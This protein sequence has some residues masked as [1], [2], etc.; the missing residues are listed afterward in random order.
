VYLLPP[1]GSETSCVVDTRRS[2]SASSH[3]ELFKL[4]E[5]D[6]EAASPPHKG[7]DSAIHLESGQQRHRARH[8]IGVSSM[9]ANPLLPPAHMQR[10]Y[11]RY[12]SP[13]ESCALA[14][15]QL[16]ATIQAADTRLNLESPSKRWGKNALWRRAERG[17]GR[18]RRRLQPDSFRPDRA[19]AG[20]RRRVGAGPGGPS[21][22]VGVHDGARQPGRRGVHAHQG[23]RRLRVGRL[24]RAVRQVSDGSWWQRRTSLLAAQAFRCRWQP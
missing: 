20:G 21:G 10:V 23:Q 5:D 24:R 12:T 8:S 15:G 18:F 9:H 19:A 17:S 22:G 14:D 11:Y 13:W 7:G 6:M 1:V 3:A 16:A 4:L 2:D